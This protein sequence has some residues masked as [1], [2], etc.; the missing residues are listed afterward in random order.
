MILT[1]TPNPA[2]D[3]TYQTSQLLPGQT[4][5]VCTPVRRA[6]GKGINVARVLHQEG[7]PVR[8]LATAGGR[9]GEELA[10]DLERTG[11]R[12][13]LVPVAAGTRSTIAMVSSDTTTIFNEPGA[14]L[15]GREWQYLAEAVADELQGAKVFVASGSLP[16]G[17]PADLYPGVIALARQQ[18]V[19]S[20]I[21]ASGAGL[22][23]AASAGA[24][25][26]KP[27]RAELAEATGEA[28]LF[29]G[30]RVLVRLGARRVLLS[31]SGNGML[32]FAAGRSSYLT[33][34][35][36]QPLAGNPTG[37]GDAAVAGAAALLHD[38]AL[39][40]EAVLDAA[41]DLERLLRRAAAWGSAAVLMP[42]AG[43]ISA[44]WPDLQ[45]KLIIEESH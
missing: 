26:L 20:I 43:E 12:H 31:D 18:G 37:A 1:L 24:D 23:A 36:P 29:A 2:I 11:L 6:G 9:T 45:E 41:D 7:L 33:A 3:L 27:N 13:R 15:S 28:D 32:G 34:R 14:P 21:D 5:R 38:A 35:L 25:L 10:E 44:E 22:L 19:P 30:V 40:D 8:V 16:D 4:H 17:A 39:S 42:L